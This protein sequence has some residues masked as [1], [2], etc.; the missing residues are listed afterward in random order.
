MRI[1]GFVPRRPVGAAGLPSARHERESEL[2]CF[3]FISFMTTKI[4]SCSLIT[5]IIVLLSGLL[6]EAIRPL[7]DLPREA[8]LHLIVGERTKRFAPRTHFH[9]G[10]LN[11]KHC[12]FVKSYRPSLRQAVTNAWPADVPKK[13]HIARSSPTMM[14]KVSA[15]GGVQLHSPEPSPHLCSPR[16]PVP[17]SSE[18]IFNQ[19][20][21][22]CYRY[23]VIGEGTVT[24]QR[25]I[26][27]A[28]YCCRTW[29][30]SR[31]RYMHGTAP[32]SRQHC[33]P[34]WLLSTYQ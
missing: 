13:G 19:P 29:P 4:D 28:E 24:L 12:V 3:N 21:V 10:A 2:H 20:N 31:E 32:C 15:G 6:G 23:A 27:W 22:L 17:C 1:R 16:C 11:V 26:L 34:F 30:S 33:L 14:S 5:V 8:L 18:E 9:Q 25:Y 7:D